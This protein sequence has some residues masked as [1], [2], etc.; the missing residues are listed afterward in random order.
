MKEDTRFHPCRYRCGRTE[1]GTQ[2]RT[3]DECKAILAE[4]AAENR[5]SR[6]PVTRARVGSAYTRGQGLSK[7]MATFGRG[8]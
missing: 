6:Q 3:C 5:R 7:V 1:W 8:V 4:I 2:S